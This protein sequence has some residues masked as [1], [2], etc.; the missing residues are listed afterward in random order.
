[1]KRTELLAPKA[2]VAGATT[3]FLTSAMGLVI[4]LVFRG[5]FDWSSGGTT[6]VASFFVLT[7]CILGGFRAGLGAPKSPLSNGAVAALMAGVAI[8][9]VQRLVSGNGIRPVTLVFV[10][11]LC[12]SLGVFGGFVANTANRTRAFRKR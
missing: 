10:A 5:L 11:L 8:S 2:I 6:A 7:G 1:M 4:A 3:A 9:F 12:S